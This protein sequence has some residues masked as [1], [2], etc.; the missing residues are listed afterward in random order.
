MQGYWVRALKTN[1]T[2][3]NDSQKLIHRWKQISTF[4]ILIRVEVRKK[5]I[6]EISSSRK[7]RIYKV[8]HTV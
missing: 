4:S 6:S 3:I 7:K 2:Y 8:M 1:L 5:N